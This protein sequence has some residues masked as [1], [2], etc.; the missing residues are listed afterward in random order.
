MSQKVLCALSLTDNGKGLIYK[1]LT[2][3][4]GSTGSW[5]TIK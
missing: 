1:T 3:S 5:V 2:D 4:I